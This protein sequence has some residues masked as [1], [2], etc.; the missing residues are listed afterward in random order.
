MLNVELQNT[1]KQHNT[2]IVKL[3]QKYAEN[4]VF[5]ANVCVVEKKRVDLAIDCLSFSQYISTPTFAPFIQGLLSGERSVSWLVG[6]RFSYRI[7]ASTKESGS[8][9]RTLFSL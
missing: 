7:S 8:R 5:A 6:G 4:G 1:K 9:S 3:L 2:L